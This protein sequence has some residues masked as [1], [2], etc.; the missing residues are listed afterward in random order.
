MA[1]DDGWID[2]A[3]VCDYTAGMTDGYA[4]KVYRRLFALVLGAAE[5]NYRVHLVVTQELFP[6]VLTLLGERS[7]DTV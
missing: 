4:E 2:A 3:Q 1:V 5:M 7:R 6:S